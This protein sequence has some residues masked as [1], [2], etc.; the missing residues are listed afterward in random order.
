MVPKFRCWLFFAIF[1]RFAITNCWLFVKLQAEFVVALDKF[2]SRL[3]WKTLCVFL[4]FFS[5]FPNFP[6]L[7]TSR[8]PIWDL[9]RICWGKMPSQGSKYQE[10][11]FTKTGSG[12]LVES[13]CCSQFDWLHTWH[14][15]GFLKTNLLFFVE[16][17][18]KERQNGWIPETGE[19]IQM[20]FFSSNSWIPSTLQTLG[21]LKQDHRRQ[22]APFSFASWY[23]VC[24]D[25]RFQTGGCVL[26]FV[27][28]LRCIS[29]N[30]AVTEVVLCG[31][32]TEVLDANKLLTS[33]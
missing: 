15:G 13:L 26:F 14:S 8:V 31:A 17:K 28:F 21:Q 19:M 2:V 7:T 20:G 23:K 24:N 30:P 27:Y 1:V 33:N 32:V 29:G 18:D 22:W 11:A 6:L 16:F 12:K 5:H 25:L 10:K 3:T 4:F 9:L